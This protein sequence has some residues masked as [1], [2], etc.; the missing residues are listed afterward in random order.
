MSGEY[1]GLVKYNAENLEE[2]ELAEQEIKRESQASTRQDQTQVVTHEG[3]D[4]QLVD[5]LDA[6]KTDIRRTKEKKSNV[7]MGRKKIQEIPEILLR[8]GNLKEYFKPE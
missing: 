1:D 7:K 6:I 3:E 2:I 5:A 8:N 4:K